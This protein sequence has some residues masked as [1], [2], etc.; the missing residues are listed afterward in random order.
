MPTGAL[1]LA[2]AGPVHVHVML[3]AD[4]RVSISPLG[5]ITYCPDRVE[6]AIGPNTHRIPAG[7]ALQVAGIGGFEFECTGQLLNDILTVAFGS[8][9]R[10]LIAVGR[11]AVP[12][13]VVNAKTREHE[14][15]I[16]PCHPGCPDVEYLRYAWVLPR[17]MPPL[18]YGYSLYTR[19]FFESPEWPSDAHSPISKLSAIALCVVR[20]PAPESRA[21]LLDHAPLIVSLFNELRR[22]YDRRHL[23]LTRDGVRTAYRSDLAMYIGAMVRACGDDFISVIALCGGGAFLRDAGFVDEIL[24]G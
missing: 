10:N 12:V 4:F 17:L 6:V 11:H 22:E 18:P 9:P 16:L 24:N 15:E 23:L 2:I 14:R 21:W 20:R 7:R 13:P 19:D 8:W 1:E 5:Q 3:P